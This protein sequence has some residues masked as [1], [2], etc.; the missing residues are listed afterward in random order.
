M[1]SFKAPRLSLGN[2]DA[3]ATASVIAAASDI[4]I[5]L[6]A[7]GVIHDLAINAEDLARDLAAGTDWLGRR[8]IETVTVE[9]RPK[10]EELLR[11][12]VA[13]R[14]PRWRHL[15]QLAPAIGS[16]PIL[17]AA[18]RLGT[19][20]RAVVF[21][22]DLRP[23][24]S[25]QQRLVE[26]QQSV[27]RDYARLRQA[28]TRY[29]L[30]FQIS[31][32]P[33]LVVDAPSGRVVEMNPAAALLF[34]KAAK[35]MVGRY[36]PEAFAPESQDSVRLLLAGVRA[37]GRADETVAPLEP[38]GREVNVAVSLLRQEE[39]TTF[40]VR[41]SPART[42]LPALALPR[43]KSKLLEA[44][45]GAPDAF[46]VTDHEGRIL[47]T[48]AA[49]LEAAQLVT[50]DQALGE[51]LG[52]WLGRQGVEMDVLTGTLRQRG[53]VRLF[54][55]TLRGEHGGTTEVEVSAVSVTEAGGRDCFGFAIRDVG[56]RLA[57]A[58]NR[59][60]PLRSVGQITELIGRVPLKDLVREATDVIE[61]LCIEAALQ[62]T[63]DNRA[64]AAELLGLSRQSLYV[65]LRRYGLGDLGPEANQLED[66]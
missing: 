57:T 15:N 17:C 26:A 10:A 51:P 30:L 61:R 47:T 65:K 12:A 39:G 49:F 23:V 66:S 40:L 8:W 43:P 55:T 20:D 44:V 28:E 4:A 59:A 16:V 56:M 6:T 36:F 45:E 1:T 50:E 14:T 32:E 41:L 48:N 5:I 58:P 22:R 19:A 25:L 64:S 18:V 24:S 62:L 34:G 3:D 13:G 29:R 7:D 2:L 53:S 31:P 54:A 21:G 46:V 38:D 33:I 11:D 63:G 35:R 42:D 37:G 27:E 9:S 52:R 60:E